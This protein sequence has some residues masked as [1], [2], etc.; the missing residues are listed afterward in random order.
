[1]EIDPKNVFH[2]KNQIKIHQKNLITD[3]DVHIIHVQR[4]LCASNLWN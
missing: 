2:A 3:V 1:M 4:L